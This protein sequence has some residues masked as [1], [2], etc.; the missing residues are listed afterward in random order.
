MDASIRTH[1][2]PEPRLCDAFIRRN[3]CLS[4]LAAESLLQDSRQEPSSSALIT[5]A[6][7]TS[8]SAGN[9]STWLGSRGCAMP[10][11]RAART[12]RAC[13]SDSVCKITSCP[14]CVRP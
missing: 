9:T 3:T 13:S 10:W 1:G 7:S 8:V 14:A 4:L 2:A 5:D 6:H 12:S 11:N